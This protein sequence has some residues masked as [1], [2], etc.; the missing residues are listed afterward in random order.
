M[1]PENNVDVIISAYI[2]SGARFPLV[3]VGGNP[4]Q[5]AFV[6][7][8]NDL[9]A[10][11]DAICLLGPI[12]DQELLNGLY[13]NCLT[14]VHG[15]SVGGTNPSLLRAMGAGAP[16]LAFDVSFN[17][18]VLGPLGHF[19]NSADVLSCLLESAEASPLS[20][21]QR[22]GNLRK[23]ARRLYNWDDVASGYEKMCRR[24]CSNSNAL[25]P[26]SAPDSSDGR[27]SAFSM[28]STIT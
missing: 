16:V 7:R 4:Y 19:F 3:V 1:E 21:L 14:Y 15:H 18:E 8:V 22:G 17:R 23:R 26:E 9:C 12:W 24:L 6:R 20:E 10:G 27:P 13:S 28:E 2:K 5:T 11:E 25:R